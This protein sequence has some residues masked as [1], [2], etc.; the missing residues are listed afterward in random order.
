MFKT[1]NILIISTFMLFGALQNTKA[2]TFNTIACAD[3][4]GCDTTSLQSLSAY[5]DVQNSNGGGLCR[6]VV[7]FEMIECDGPP[8][9]IKVIMKN[10]INIG[11]DNTPGPDADDI[12]TAANKA[13]LIKA[14]V[15]IG[16]TAPATFELTTPSCIKLQIG[17]LQ[18]TGDCGDCCITQYTLYNGE[19]INP[20]NYS[21]IEDCG[22]PMGAPIGCDPV[23]EHSQLPTGK[24]ENYI[25]PRCGFESYYELIGFVL[26]ELS[27]DMETEF[28]S[29]IYSGEDPGNNYHLTIINLFTYPSS[30]DLIEDEN[31]FRE[32]V[33]F[34]FANLLDYM[35]SSYTGTFNDSTD[36]YNNLF[37]HLNSCWV[38]DSLHVYPCSNECC[39]LEFEVGKNGNGDIFV[40]Y[41]GN[42]V[43]DTCTTPCFEVCEE[44]S[45]ISTPTPKLIFG[46]NVKTKLFKGLEIIPNPSNGETKIKFKSQQ[47]GNIKISINDING[48]EILRFLDKKE[49]NQYEYQF[50]SAKLSNGMY[51]INI[52]VENVNVSNGKLIIQK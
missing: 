4:T 34:I 49:I 21:T 3:T 6:Y 18:I 37:L 11:C 8:P 43:P 41:V 25:F 23:C 7:G 48:N 44:I 40:N 39:T 51:F 30:V 33:E 50:N 36:M 45:N 28:F 12:M 24:I 32:V 27:T 17:G 15:T 9:V 22:F 29:N 14:N 46:Q 38:Q 20:V 47:N 1:L 31:G 2:T 52:Y 13:A 42:N 10:I 35:P 19:I 5:F 16:N 26:G